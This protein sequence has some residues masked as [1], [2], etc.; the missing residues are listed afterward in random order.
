VLLLAAA[1]VAG[2]VHTGYRRRKEH[3]DLGRLLARHRGLVIAPHPLGLPAAGYAGAFVSTPRGDR[4]FGLQHAIEG[5]LPARCDGQAQQLPCATFRWWYE[6]RRRRAGH[7]SATRYDRRRTSVT[8]VRLPADVPRRIALRPESVLG[9]AGLTRGG[10]QLESAEFNRRFRVECRDRTLT[11]H[12]LDAHL[13]RLLIEAFTG[14]S[15]E[16][17]GDLLV[18]GG[19]PD[20]RDPTLAGVIGEFPAMRQ[21]ARRL[22]EAIPAAFWRAVAPAQE[23]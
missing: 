19:G 13:Q 18:V 2:L 21:D 9:R 4:R 3:H 5:P 1:V 17:R 11:L 22:V 16:L 15:I 7:G 20:H 12:L 23:R 10:H 8:V 14:R 6:V